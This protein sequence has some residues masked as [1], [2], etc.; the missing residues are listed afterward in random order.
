M[1]RFLILLGCV[2]FVLIF[3]GIGLF[4]LALLCYVHDDTNVVANAAL[5]LV[6]IG[7]GVQ[8]VDVVKFAKECR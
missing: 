8:I 5:L 6:T 7:C 4:T 3:A 2:L 1:I